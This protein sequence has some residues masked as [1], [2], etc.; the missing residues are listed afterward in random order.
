MEKRKLI[1]A[2]TVFSL[3]LATGFVMQNGDA[4]ASRLGLGNSTG[5]GM[6]SVQDIQPVSAS[7]VQTTPRLA[8]VP[9]KIPHV[10]ISSDTTAPLPQDPS[11]QQGFSTQSDS[12]ARRM[13]DVE[14][15]L[16]KTA[17]GR[18]HQISA[19][20]L[21]CDVT[22]L[23]DPGAS[24]MVDLTLTAPCYAG[25]PV[26]IQHGDLK[27]TA[28]TDTVGTLSI[29]VPALSVSATFEAR[30]DNGATAE[31]MATVPGADTFERV[32]LQWQ[33]VPAMHIHAFEDGST[34]DE[35]G[36]VTAKTPRSP[37]FAQSRDGG[38]LTQLGNG[39]VPGGWLAEVYSY[40]AA[41]A[42]ASGIV[43]LNIEAEIS[44]QTCGRDVFAETL[45]NNPVGGFQTA[46]LSLS[47]P[48]CD[49]IGDFLVL[50]HI[51]RDMK[52]AAK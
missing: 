43:R 38:F 46:Q 5:I 47:M 37:D 23:A 28:V 2:G 30:F 32:A 1:M 9:T 16:P 7:A 39:A 12:L 6:Y 19:F 33:G 15:E 31:T 42:R 22:F 27:F 35:P 3:A 52:L 17:P 4:I 50:K 26:T 34:Y 24:A 45:Q 51:L 25:S 29:S 14:P 41:N 40:P 10:Q 49:A 8:V 13:S 11:A 44:A 20:G 21:P 48:G 18:H 36:H